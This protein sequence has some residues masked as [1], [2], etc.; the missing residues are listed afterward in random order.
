MEEMI[1]FEWTLDGL[2]K[3]FNDVEKEEGQ[4]YK[5]CVSDYWC[6]FRGAVR[7]L[8]GDDN[9]K[10]VVERANELMNNN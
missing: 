6:G 9:F 1:K 7:S 2:A 5:G 10:R 8:I 4:V 3:F